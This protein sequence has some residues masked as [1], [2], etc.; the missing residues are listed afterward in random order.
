MDRKVG[1]NQLHQMLS[2][3][4]MASNFNDSTTIQFFFLDSIG[5]TQLAVDRFGLFILRCALR[6]SESTQKS[7]REGKGKKDFLI[8][9]L[10]CNYLIR[11]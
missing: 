2:L 10:Q 1:K 8:I 6:L 3:D 5:H 11:C 9:K 7:H 4:L